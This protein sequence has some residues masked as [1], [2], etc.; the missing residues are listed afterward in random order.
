MWVNLI[1]NVKLSTILFSETKKATLSEVE[2]RI[3]QDALNA[4]IFPPGS[5]PD[6]SPLHV[7]CCNDTCS[8]TWTGAEHINQVTTVTMNFLFD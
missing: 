7:V 5:N 8:F 3:D 2:S 1:V 4:M 6:Y